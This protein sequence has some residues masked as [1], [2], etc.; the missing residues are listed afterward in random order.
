MIKDGKMYFDMNP[1]AG[2]WV[3]WFICDDW[4]GCS[5]CHKVI[6]KDEKVYFNWQTGSFYCAEHS[7]LAWSKF[8]SGRSS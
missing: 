6:N 1:E 5:E 3:G 4:V 8:K 2:T 7:Q